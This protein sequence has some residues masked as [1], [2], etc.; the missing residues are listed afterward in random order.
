[1]YAR[2]AE[3][4]RWRIEILNERG[5]LKTAPASFAADDPERG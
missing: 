4:Q 2:Y 5:E 1:M 3:Q